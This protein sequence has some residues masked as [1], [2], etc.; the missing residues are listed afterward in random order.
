MSDRFADSTMAYQGYGYGNNPVQQ[1]LISDLYKEVVGNFK[2]SLT[3]LLDIPVE[4]G[5]RRS[6]RTDNTEL[7]FEDKE[8]S[9][10]ERLRNAY[11]MMAK[12]EPDRFVVIDATQPIEAIHQQIMNVM[13][14]KGLLPK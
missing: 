9:F 13:K 4:I 12:G 7:R 1:K 11:L 10:H 3:I 8:M 14:E 6:R 5:L 2:P